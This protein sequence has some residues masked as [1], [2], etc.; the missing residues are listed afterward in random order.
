[1]RAFG[2]LVTK[3]E[4]GKN[5]ETRCCNPFDSRCRP[6]NPLNPKTR[7]CD[8]SCNSYEVRGRATA[9]HSGELPLPDPNVCR[10]FSGPEMRNS[11]L[12]LEI[13]PRCFDLPPADL[14][15]DNCLQYLDGEASVCYMR[16]EKLLIDPRNVV[17]WNA[18][19]ETDIVLMNM[20]LHH[21]TR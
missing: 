9:G 16:A 13:D 2:I 12:G 5:P 14:D 19:E 1:M 10:E 7:C 6:K 17:Y 3:I 18:L 21:S 15:H 11:T 8:S 4:L 20:G